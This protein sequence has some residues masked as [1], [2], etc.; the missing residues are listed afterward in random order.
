MTINENDWSYRNFPV[1]LLLKFGGEACTIGAMQR[2]LGR[3]E[4]VRWG[5]RRIKQVQMKRACICRPL[6]VGGRQE[7]RTPDLRLR[8]PALYPTELTALKNPLI[9]YLRLLLKL[10][11]QNYYYTRLLF[12]SSLC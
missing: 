2:C 6:L 4:G 1:E 9:L 12:F 10:K 11:F 8:R 5:K 3:V 7:A